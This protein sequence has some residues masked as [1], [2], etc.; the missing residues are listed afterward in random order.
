[1]C[2][3]Y[4]LIILYYVYDTKVDYK[5]SYIKI[6]IVQIPF[7]SQSNRVLRRKASAPAALQAQVGH[8]SQHTN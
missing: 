1:M 7:K 3:T 5:C 2:Y 4:V 6:A 8:L